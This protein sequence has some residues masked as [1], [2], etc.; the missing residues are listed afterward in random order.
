MQGVL[1]V[2]PFR[3]GDTGR[4]APE[5]LSMLE[6]PVGRHEERYPRRKKEI[7]RAPESLCCTTRWPREHR[8]D[9]K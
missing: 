1:A 9:K 4:I 3:R 6:G 7:G 8:E 5:L 2:I